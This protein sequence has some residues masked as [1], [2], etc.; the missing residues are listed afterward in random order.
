MSISYINIHNALSISYVT[1]EKIQEK[2]GDF[3]GRERE[4]ERSRVRA[5]LRERVCVCVRERV[6][7]GGRE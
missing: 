4:R 6:S 2:D 5:R 7:E 3:R 1:R